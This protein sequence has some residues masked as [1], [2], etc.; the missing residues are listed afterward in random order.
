MDLT[1]ILTLIG[2]FAAVIAVIIGL[3]LYLASKIDNL[4]IVVYNEMKDFHGRLCAIEENNKL[5]KNK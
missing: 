5:N 4:Q 1:T 2:C 3:F